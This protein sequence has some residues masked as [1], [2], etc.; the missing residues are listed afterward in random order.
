MSRKLATIRTIKD[1]QPIPDADVIERIQID[2]WWCVSKKGEFKIGDKCVYFEIDS[3]L[4]LVKQFEFLASRGTKKMVCDG[5]EVE[6][7]RLRTIKLRGQISQGL[8]LPLS[9]F[10]E[11]DESMD[12]VT[13]L[14]NVLLYEPPIPACLYGM[15][16]GNFPNFIP[17]T[18]EERVQNAQ[19]LLDKYRGQSFTVTEKLDGTS[20]TYF[21]YEGRFG[22]CGRNWEYKDTENNTYWEIAH[23]YD[24]MNLIPEGYAVQGEIVGEGI[25]K[26]KLKIKGH[27]LRI[28]YVWDIKN[29]KYVN[30]NVI[31]EL[32]GMPKMK[33]V[34]QVPLLNVNFTLNHTIDEL[35]SMAEGKS[36]LCETTE[37]EGIVFVLNNSGYK[38][39]FKAISNKFLANEK[40]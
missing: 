5:N 35:L 4:P 40:D 31:F 11:V 8:A 6:G 23:K 39:S 25:Q 20:S 30:S 19:K 26:N 16:H 34:P 37:R 3:L 29:K 32:W 14:L 10:T 9:L 28:F 38:V 7:Y 33:D 2:G 1:I 21:N 18:D 12:D 24:L 22:V 15:I 27:E 13:E 36:K 17:K